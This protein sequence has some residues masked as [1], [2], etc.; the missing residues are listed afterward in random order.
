MS[1][2][3]Q[4]GFGHVEKRDYTKSIYQ[5]NVIILQREEWLTHVSFGLVGICLELN[6]IYIRR[7][8]RKAFPSSIMTKLE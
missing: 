2:K 8:S 4:G 5:K 6:E 3:D 7:S 1:E